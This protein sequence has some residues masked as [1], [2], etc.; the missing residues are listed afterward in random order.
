[1]LSAVG[2][3]VLR[4][5]AFYPPRMTWVTPPLRL[6]LALALAG[7]VGVVASEAVRSQHGV[8]IYLLGTPVGW[9]RVARVASEAVALLLSLAEHRLTAAA[10]VFAA[11]AIAFAGHASAVRLMPGGVF[12]DAIH[13]LSAGMWAGAIV[14]L[15]TLKPPGGWGSEAGLGLLE[16]FGRVALI[17]FA[18][19]ALTGVIGAAQDLRGV[20]DLWATSYGVVLGAKVVGVLAMV[21]VSGLVWSRRL[22]FRRSEAVLALFVVAATAVLASYPMPPAGS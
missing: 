13:V 22:P 18:V 10:A 14:G 12:T 1:L 16:R 17:A 2:M 6:A 21:V 3:L 7:G 15:A 20:A 5:L 4:R 8:L 9:V 11:G 19:T